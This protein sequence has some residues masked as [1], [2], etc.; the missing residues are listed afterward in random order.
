MTRHRPVPR[1]RIAVSSVIIAV[2][3]GSLTAC[4]SSGG[5]QS[6]PPSGSS[7][8]LS[9]AK[10]A[11]A[12]LSKAPTDI[13][14]TEPLQ[15]PSSL[16]G[17]TFVYM[18]CAAPICQL[19]APDL[20]DAA[21]ALGVSLK[22]IN[23]GAT[24]DTINSAW[25]Q[26]ASMLPK[27][28]AVIAPANPPQLFS[29]QLGQ[30]IK[31]GTKVILFNTPNPVPAGVSAVVFPPKD[32]GTLGTATANFVYADSGGKPGRT[33]YI[34][35]P[36]YAALQGGP[37]DYSAQMKQLC[38]SCAVHVLNVQPSEIG[39]QIPSKV[40]SYLQAHPDVKYVVPQYGDLEIGVPQAILGA[41][42]KLP[43]LI[44]AEAEPANLQL[45]KKG[46]E[47]ADAAHFL[48]YL[49]WVAV[50]SAAR[51]VLGQPIT[52]PAAPIQWL[53]KGDVTFDVKTQHPAFGVDF[54]AQFEKLWAGQ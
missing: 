32:S 24:P 45:L 39:Q 40:V 33:L 30:L 36:Q 20:A 37:N 1:Y 2:A 28:A 10:K 54:R 4:S 13:G 29:A 26:L 48:D 43:K 41:G 16:K 5:H 27:P 8:A 46:Q 25:N 21:K 53:T 19:Y 35:T 42:I 50:D 23:T 52:V 38:S 9:A 44:T 11:V 15:D 51:A 31:V 34:D 18:S 47:Y 17:K 49:F 14:I 6:A 3:A 12:D 7:A 22:T